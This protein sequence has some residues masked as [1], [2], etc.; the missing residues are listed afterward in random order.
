MVS[1]TPVVISN[2]KD[3]IK[4]NQPGLS[5]SRCCSFQLYI[6]MIGITQLLSIYKANNIFT[7]RYYT[8]FVIP[9]DFSL[10]RFV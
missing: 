5:F 10:Q 2:L 6:E 8:V 9:S 4:T 7:M 3:R 1:S